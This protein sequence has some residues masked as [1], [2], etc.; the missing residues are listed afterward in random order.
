MDH[1]VPSWPLDA[2]RSIRASR[3]A[4]TLTSVP[5]TSL[6]GATDEMALAR[7]LAG[8]PMPSITLQR[9]N[10]KR[11]GLQTLSLG[12]VVFYLYPGT[13]GTSAAGIDS[14][15]EDTAQHRAYCEREYRFRELGVRTVGI[16][17]QQQLEQLGTIREHHIE[18]LMLIDPDLVLAEALGLPTFELSDRLW[19][20][21]LTLLVHDGMIERVFYPVATAANNPGQVLTWLQLHG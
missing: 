13:D 18:H 21:R 7:G 12:W 9:I 15:S 3:C 1:R 11:I 6:S 19:Y 20:R 16:S 17:S 14:P 10:G 8:S 5:K 2:R 4:T